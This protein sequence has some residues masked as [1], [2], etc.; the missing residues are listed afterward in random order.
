MT[1]EL[2]D[3]GYRWTTEYGRTLLPEDHGSDLEALA[4]LL[5]GALVNFRRTQWTFGRAPLKLSEDR[6][7]AAWTTVTSVLIEALP[8]RALL[9]AGT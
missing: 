6:L 5:V 3:S 7:L 4:V 8:A 9:E 1:R 2:I